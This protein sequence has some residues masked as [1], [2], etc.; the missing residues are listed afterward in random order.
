MMFAFI[1]MGVSISFL[2]IDTFTHS[3]HS[4]TKFGK[5]DTRSTETIL[6]FKEQGQ[7]LITHTLSM[8]GSKLSKGLLYTYPEERHRTQLNLWEILCHLNYSII[9]QCFIL[10]S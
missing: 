6:A 1:K 8:E 10:H 2:I 4:V 5:T 3:T 7:I 9:F